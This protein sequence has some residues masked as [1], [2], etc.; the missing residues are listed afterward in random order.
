MSLANKYRPKTWD[1]VVE[2]GVAVQILRKICESDEISNR[3]FL[4]TGSAGCGKTTLA[5]IVARTLNGNDVNCIELDG[6]S[7]NGVDA[8]RDIIAQ[9]STYPIGSKYKVII[10]DECHA[11]SSNAWQ[12]L[13]VVLESAPARSIFILCTTNPEKIPKTITS[14]VQQF[15]LAKIT[16][17]GIQDRLKYVLDKEISEG[18]ELTYT[19]DALN[20]IAKLALGGLRDALTM[21]DKVLVYSSDITYASVSAALSTPNYDNYFLLL[22]SVAKRDNKQII[23]IVSDVYN[24]G[25]NFVKW[26]EDFHSFIINIMK[27]IITKDIDS[28]TIPTYYAEKLSNYGNTHYNLCLQMVQL[29]LSINHELRTTNYQQEVVLTKLCGTIA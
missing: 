27:F 15:R 8:M 21:L 4:L 19:D 26:F 18:S 5:R 13:L 28:T 16:A 25:V 6:A 29:L 22:N 10:I 20:Y 1:D 2:Q 14:R 12:S 24:S 17:K 3:N 11:L 7:N 23:T 9:A